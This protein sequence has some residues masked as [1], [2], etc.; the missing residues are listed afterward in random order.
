MTQVLTVSY[1][2]SARYCQWEEEEEVYLGVGDSIW[3]KQRLGDSGT[4]G[5]RSPRD[6]LSDLRATTELT[7]TTKGGIP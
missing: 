4:I 6:E 2:A 1:I 5:L 3:T 7:N